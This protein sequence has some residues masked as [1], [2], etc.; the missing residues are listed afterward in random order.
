MKRPIAA[1]LLTVCLFA[2]VYAYTSFVQSIAREPLQVQESFST[3]KYSVRISRTCDL[4]G[5]PGFDEIYALL[6]RFRGKDLV[7][8]EDS[9]PKSEKVEEQ[10][11][12]VTVN[13][14]EISV[15]AN[16]KTADGS[17][18][19]WGNEDSADSTEQ[20]CAV[21]V[22]VLQGDRTIADQT[23]WQEPGNPFIGGSV[24]FNGTPADQHEH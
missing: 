21:R 2:G 10:L 11:E 22:Q 24:S 4:V 3:D 14:N 13:E 1:L 17:S 6:V 7:L 18:D 15:T 20:L 23:I 8:H 16:V 12:G 5:D 9:L 19:D